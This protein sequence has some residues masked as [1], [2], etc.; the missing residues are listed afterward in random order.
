MNLYG[1]YGKAQSK[2]RTRPRRKSLSRR[3]AE[4]HKRAASNSRIF[5]INHGGENGQTSGAELPEIRSDSLTGRLLPVKTAYG[6]KRILFA[7]R[8]SWEEAI[9]QYH[10]AAIHLTSNYSFLYSHFRKGKLIKKP[11]DTKGETHVEYAQTRR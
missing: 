8:L 4:K 9:M 7:V 11:D 3:P 6:S 2:Q 10:V 1:A 5:R